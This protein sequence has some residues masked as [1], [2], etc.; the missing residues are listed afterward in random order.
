MPPPEKE[1]FDILDP[2]LLAFRTRLE[3]TILNHAVTAYLRGSAQMVS[4]GRTLL[5]KPIY[6]EGPPMQQAIS[7][8]NKHAA[9]LVT[10]M[11]LETKDRLAKVIADGIQNKRG[12][13]GLARDIRKGFDDMTKYRSQ[14]IARTETA[15]A[16]SKGSIDRME[17]MGVT[18]KEWVTVGDDKV[19]DECLGNEAEG[20]VPIDHV[21]SG[22]VLNPPQHPDCRCSLAP[23]MLK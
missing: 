10:E 8:A 3:A 6:F 1:V 2:I 23:V 13:D 7:Y 11:D 15:G 19:S 4:F 9:R 12:I 17:D 18:G 21:F 16:L 22:G 20:A 14:L 5:D